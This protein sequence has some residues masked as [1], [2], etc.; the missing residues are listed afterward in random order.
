MGSFPFVPWVKDPV[1][2]MQWPQS[3]LRCRFSSQ[4]VNFH[5]LQ[6]QPPPTK[7]KKKK[8]RK[9]QKWSKLRFEPW[10]VSHQG[11]ELGSE[12]NSGNEFKGIQISMTSCS[13]LLLLS[14]SLCVY[15]HTHIYT[16]LP[17]LSMESLKYYTF[18]FVFCPFLGPHQRHMEVPRPGV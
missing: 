6:A 5:M 10:F 3:L 4:P 11:E 12:Y 1:S 9:E 13:L 2:S 17:Q 16:H 7:K 15:M 8:E 18:F 14:L